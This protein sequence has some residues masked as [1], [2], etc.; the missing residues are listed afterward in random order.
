MLFNVKKNLTI[1]GHRGQ[2][3]G[4]QVEGGLGVGGQGEGGLGV[5]GQGE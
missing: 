1:P 2:G 4:G 3:A 5:K